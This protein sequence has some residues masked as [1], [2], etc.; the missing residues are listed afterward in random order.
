[1]NAIIVEGKP[2]GKFVIQG[3]G[4]GPGPTVSALVSDICSILRGNIN[5]PFSASQ[6]N[7]KKITSL[8]LSNKI[9]DTGKKIGEKVWRLPLD[10]NYNK[11]MNSSIADMQN[12]NYVGGAGSTTAAQFLGGDTFSIISDF[13]F[14]YPYSGPSWIMR[15][16]C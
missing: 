16:S 5:F 9:F 11:L 2:I 10:E 14:L 8:D 1:M 3:E 4:A 13:V 15:H 6:A 12:I 7:R